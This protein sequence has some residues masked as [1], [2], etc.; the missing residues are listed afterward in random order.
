MASDYSERFREH[1]DSLESPCMWPLPHRHKHRCNC[2]CG[3]ERGHAGRH[4]CVINAPAAPL[5]EEGNNP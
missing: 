4:D 3:K 2:A 1:Y 5:V